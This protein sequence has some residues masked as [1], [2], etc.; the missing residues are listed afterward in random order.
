MIITSN[1]CSQQTPFAKGGKEKIQRLDRVSCPDTEIQVLPNLGIAVDRVSCPDTNIG[2]STTRF[3]Q[4]YCFNE[5]HAFCSRNMWVHVQYTCAKKLVSSNF[6]KILHNYIRKKICSV[7]Y[8]QNILDQF[9]LKLIQILLWPEKKN[10]CRSNSYSRPK[11]K[12]NTT[13]KHNWNKGSSSPRE[14]SVFVP[15]SVI[16]SVSKGQESGVKEC[17]LY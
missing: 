2:V 10:V 5:T 6:A 3:P 9:E 16:L 14:A 17:K 7:V 13:Q 11:P 12:T 1:R 8:V 15:L 4:A